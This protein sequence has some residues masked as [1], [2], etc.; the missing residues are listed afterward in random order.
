M[1]LF[2]SAFLLKNEMSVEFQQLLVVLDVF[3]ITCCSPVL[4]GWEFYLSQCSLYFLRVLTPLVSFKLGKFHHHQLLGAAGAF[5]LTSPLCHRRELLGESSLP[6]ALCRAD[7]ALCKE[8]PPQT[9][10]CQCP[11]TPSSAGRVQAALL[12]L[13]CAH[14]IASF[15]AVS[16]RSSDNVF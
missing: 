11:E 9:C 5:V 3:K 7:P 10:R 4:Q 6:T 12:T 2:H 13:G 8:F 14:R 16:S 15:S 1:V